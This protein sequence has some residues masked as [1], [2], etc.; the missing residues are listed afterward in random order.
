MSNQEKTLNHA[1]VLFGVR[2]WRIVSTLRTYG[3]EDARH[4]VS[5]HKPYIACKVPC[6]VLC[7]G[8]GSVGLMHTCQHKSWRVSGWCWASASQSSASSTLRML[9]QHR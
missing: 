4:D 1:L 2:V 3:G 7:A 9:V 6:T 5:F 8:T